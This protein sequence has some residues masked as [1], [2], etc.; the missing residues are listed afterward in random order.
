ML[1]AV[2]VRAAP[3]K[4]TQ[5][6]TV[7]HISPSVVRKQVAAATAPLPAMP[8]PMPTPDPSPEPAPEPAAIAPPEAEPE[9]SAPEPPPPKKSESKP[10]KEPKPT[11]PAPKK[12]A[13]PKKTN[14][15]A[16]KP[17]PKAEPSK[18]KAVAAEPK[19]EVS[20]KETS[21]T[22]TKKTTSTTKAPVAKPAVAKTPA[23]PA[24]KQLTSAQKA[25]LDKARESIAKL[26]AIGTGS[27]RESDSSLSVPAAIQSLHI[28]SGEGGSLTG[29]ADA[30][31][32]YNRDVA[33][34]IKTALKL[35]DYGDVKVQLTISADGR[36]E[37]MEVLKFASN[38]NRDYI[39]KVLP[40][41]RLP[42]LG[43]YFP[44]CKRLVC[45]LVLSNEES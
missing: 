36:I 26:G 19:K 30:Q 10:K 21:T 39:A 8:A 28:D 22:G 4:V 32:D 45:T 20:K 12:P 5:P 43:P 35:T 16:A 33:R 3:K 42:A 14:K 27:A 25:A 24:G 17:T 13:P 7:R 9:T 29:S 34:R 31:A 38:T 18:P 37:K 23:K 2:G 41:V 11:P 40:S 15:P 44:G 1:I 6:I